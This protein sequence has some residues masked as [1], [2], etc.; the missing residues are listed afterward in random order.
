MGIEITL[1][2]GDPTTNEAA[3]DAFR[4]TWQEKLADRID[5]ALVRLREVATATLLTCSWAF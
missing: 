1:G 4:N 5:A 3:S 2:L